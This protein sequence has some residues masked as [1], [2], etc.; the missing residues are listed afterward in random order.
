M[1]NGREPEG[2]SPASGKDAVRIMTCATDEEFEAMWDEMIEQLNGFGYEQLFENDCAAWQPEIDAKIADR[3]RRNM[4][5]RQMP[6][7]VDPFA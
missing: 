2:V 4:H 5:K 3:E 1:E 6:V 7:V